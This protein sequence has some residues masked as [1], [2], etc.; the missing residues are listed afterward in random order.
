LWIDNEEGSQ[1]YWFDQ[2]EF[3]WET[4]RSIKQVRERIWEPD[5]AAVYVLAEQLKTEYADANPSDDCSVW[6]DLL[7]YVLGEVDWHEIAESLI[8]D[9]KEEQEY[10]E[11]A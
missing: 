11:V 4:R 10:E 2:A 1:R 7:G 8:E 5:R 3:V 6:S 9:W